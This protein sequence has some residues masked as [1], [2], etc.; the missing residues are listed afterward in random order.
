MLSPSDFLYLNAGQGFTTGDPYG[1]FSSW[2]MIYEN[3][4]VFPA[5][6]DRTRILG[7]EAPLWGE[8]CNEEALDSQL[9]LR[10]SA[11]AERVWSE[12]KLA[13]ADITKKL[14]DLGK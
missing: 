7:A 11:F 9:W 13:T 3:F 6:V 14:V 5:G 4:T 1:H 2:R 8:V 12:K 10:A